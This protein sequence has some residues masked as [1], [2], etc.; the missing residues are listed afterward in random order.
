MAVADVA[1][2]NDQTIGQAQE[3]AVAAKR[4]LGGEPALMRR[5]NSKVVDEGAAPLKKTPRRGDSSEVAIPNEPIASP[6]NDQ[7]PPP[8]DQTVPQQPDESSQPNQQ[9]LQPHTVI[10]QTQPP[11]NPP[12]QQVPDTTQNPK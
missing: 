11:S 2:T 4:R 12:N 7:A 3:A 6:S 1:V 9:P 5:D 10:P 8:T